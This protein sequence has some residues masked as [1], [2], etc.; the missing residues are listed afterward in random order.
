MIHTKGGYD[1]G[2]CPFLPD[3]GTDKHLEVKIISQADSLRQ[4]G[5]YSLKPGFLPPNTSKDEYSTKE[6]LFKVVF[7]STR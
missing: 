7:C 4:P 6:Y 2:L 1:F 5:H 3:I